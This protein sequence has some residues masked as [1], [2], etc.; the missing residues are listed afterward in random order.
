[1]LRLEK[2]GLITKHQSGLEVYHEL[3]PYGAKILDFIKD[4][5]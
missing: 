3:T 4:L 5:K 2:S 1:L